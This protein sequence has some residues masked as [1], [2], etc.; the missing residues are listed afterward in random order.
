MYPMFLA[1]KYNDII[2]ANLCAIGIYVANYADKFLGLRTID[3][4]FMKIFILYTLYP[5]FNTVLG[6]LSSI[7][8]VSIISSFYL[9]DIE[10]YNMYISHI[11]FDIISIIGVTA[12]REEFYWSTRNSIFLPDIGFC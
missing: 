7:T 11:I 8:L 9:C 10:E 2:V 6:A 1:Y 3:I 5:C 4:V 12:H